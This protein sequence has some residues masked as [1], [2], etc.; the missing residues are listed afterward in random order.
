[1]KR[2]SGSIS[3]ITT[4]LRAWAHRFAFL[5]LI[6]SAF[7]LMLLGK[8]DTLLVERARSTVTDAVAPLLD[9]ASRPADAINDMIDSLGE[10]A[11][12]RGENALLRRENDRLRSWQA[13]ARELEAE[14]A[15][16]R[17]LT[18][19]VPDSSLRFVSARVIGDPGGAFAR[20]VLVNAGAREGVVKGQAAITSNGLAGR[21][22]EVGMQSARVL[23]VTDINSRIPVAV[24]SGRDRAIL[25]GDNSVRPKLLYLAPGVDVAPG[26]RVVTSGHGGAFPP[27]LPVGIVSQVGEGALRIQPFVDWAHLEY[28]RLADY[29]L[30]GVLMAPG[31]MNG[32]ISADANQ[33]REHKGAKGKPQRAER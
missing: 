17:E 18:H 23:L 10:M 5:L 1:M 26:D 15:A 24:G 14:N 22:A 16:L 27:G 28:L 9:A 2:P 3:H 8:M 32:T 13:L 7:G 30:S 12:L 11:D 6:A 4:P 25:A 21:V 29:E 31:A 20:S 19:A 33:V